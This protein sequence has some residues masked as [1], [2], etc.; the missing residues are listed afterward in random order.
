MAASPHSCAGRVNVIHGHM[1]AT[2][3]SSH[4]EEVDHDWSTTR[5]SDKGR[6]HESMCPNVPNSR[7]Y[8]AQIATQDSRAETELCNS[9][10]SAGVGSAY[11]IRTRSSYSAVLQCNSCKTSKSKGLA[12]FTAQPCPPKGYSQWTSVDRK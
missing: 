3:A 10:H 5:C 8:R 4:E 2:G 1:N 7:P 12:G 6:R 9:K 11:G